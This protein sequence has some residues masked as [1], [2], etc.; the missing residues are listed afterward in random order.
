M[1]KVRELTGDATPVEARPMPKYVRQA[2]VNFNEL[3]R[4][5]CG[6][7]LYAGS[8]KGGDAHWDRRCVPC[9]CV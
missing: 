3:D 2:S 5:G 8:G 7:L 9:V 1:V 4:V 6:E